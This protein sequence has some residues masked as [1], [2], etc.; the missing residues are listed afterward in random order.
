MKTWIKAALAAMGTL[1]LIIGIPVALYFVFGMIALK[2]LT[3]M[4]LVGVT[5][6]ML[7]LF[8][9]SFFDQRR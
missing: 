9:Y 8:F 6:G 1:I 2:V 3:L 7:T 5:V 4:A